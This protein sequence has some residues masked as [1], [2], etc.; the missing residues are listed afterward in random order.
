[1]FGDFVNGRIWGLFEPCS[2]APQCRLLIDTGLN[3]SSCAKA[4]NAELF[5][6]ACSGEL[7]RIRP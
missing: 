6:I 2:D 3:I 5:V 1:V 4:S 7:Y